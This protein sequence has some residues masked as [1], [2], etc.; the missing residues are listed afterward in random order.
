MEY[1]IEVKRNKVFKYTEHVFQVM[2][3]ERN[4]IQKCMYCQILR[5]DI[6]QICGCLG[7]RLTWGMEYKG[8]Q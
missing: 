4:Q 3:N 8:A 7:L 6:Q 5:S 2:L 1:Y